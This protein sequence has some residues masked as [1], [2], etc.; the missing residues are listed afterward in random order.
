[1]VQARETY[2]ARRDLLVDR[3]ARAGWEVPRP[4][5][6]M[7]IWA[8]LPEKFRAMGSMDFAAFLLER[9]EVVVSPGVGFGRYGERYVRLA[10]VENEQ[11]L[12]Q[13]ARNI[14]KALQ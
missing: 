8:P 5:A 1:V 14:A 3:L 2:Q 9:A 11:R 4:P 7:Y 6:T 10:L 13:A 12:R